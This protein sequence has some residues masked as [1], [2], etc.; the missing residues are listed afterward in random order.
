MLLNNDPHS[1][2]W[3]D[4]VFGATGV[5]VW[6]EQWRNYETKWADKGRVPMLS[7]FGKRCKRTKQ[8]FV[9]WVEHKKWCWIESA[10]AKHVFTFLLRISVQNNRESS[11]VVLVRISEKVKQSDNFVYA[12][13]NMFHYH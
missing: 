13:T 7:A 9:R 5:K 11:D 1:Y 2:R 4:D 8:H 12:I 3:I 10:Y 6:E